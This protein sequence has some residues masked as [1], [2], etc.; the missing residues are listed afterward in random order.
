MPFL[1]QWTQNA[2]PCTQI[3]PFTDGIE[4]PVQTY[5]IHRSGNLPDGNVLATLLRLV[6][7]H[8]G[9]E[10]DK[11]FFLQ[12]SGT[13]VWN[14]MALNYANIFMRNLESN[15]LS[16]CPLQLMFYER[17]IDH[18]FIIRPHK[19]ETLLR[20]R[21]TFNSVHPSISFTHN[22]SKTELN[23]LDVRVVIEGTKLVTQLYR[24]PTDRKY[25]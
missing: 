8:N 9:F 17:Y 20:F 14:W 11:N 4:S 23:F 10:F 13:A 25:I 1:Q 18:K 7:E 6:L 2:T 15:F 21:E 12:T 24:K 16:S 5:N 22:T 3:L 19:E